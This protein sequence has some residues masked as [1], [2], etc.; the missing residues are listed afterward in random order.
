MAD[1]FCYVPFAGLYLAMASAAC[2][3]ASPSLLRQRILW[4]TLCLAVALLL[5]LTQRQ[6]SR[7]TT[8]ETLFEHTLA[9]TKNNWFIHGNYATY[10][11]KNGRYREALGHAQAAARIMPAHARAWSQLSSVLLR[12]GRAEEAVDAGR[13]AV[14]L[15][16]TDPDMRH[17]LAMALQQSG[18]AEEAVM[19]Y[20]AALRADPDRWET[21]NNLGV[22]LSAMGHSDEATGILTHA[23]RAAPGRFE[24]HFNLGSHCTRIRDYACGRNAF[25]AALR[26]RPSD[27]AALAGSAAALVGLGDTTAACAELAAARRAGADSLVVRR[28]A[29]EMGVVLGRCDDAR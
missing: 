11:A 17:A 10:L 4:A 22:L 16:P 8:S 3:W 14:D 25:A 21:L 13:A 7:W 26:I 29:G 20:R 15:A 6:V 27:P 1:R 9:V 23:C 28:M 2:L 19:H 5:G 12:L 24:S 18:R